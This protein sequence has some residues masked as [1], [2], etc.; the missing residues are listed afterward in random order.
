MKKSLKLIIVAV[1]LIIISI[2]LFVIV[3][4]V[5]IPNS[6][7]NAA[8]TLM[9]NGN[10]KE[11]IAAFELLEGY[12]DSDKKIDECNIAIID[13]KYNNAISKMNEAKFTE[14]VSIFETLNGY[15][16]SVDKIKECNTAINNNNYNEALS[17][18]DSGDIIKAYE[19]LVSLNGYKD[20]KEKAQSIFD[21]YKSEKLKQVN[22]GDFVFFGSYE[23][24]N[25][26]SNGKEDVEWLV[27]DKED[28]KALLISKYALDYISYHDGSSYTSIWELCD[29][30]EWLN[31]NF[32]NSA[33]STNEKTMIPTVENYTSERNPFYD[34]TMLNSSQ[35]KIFILDINEAKKY[36]S[37]NSARICK[38]TSYAITHRTN[39]GNN[40]C[41]WWLRGAGRTQQTLAMFVDDD[42]TIDDFGTMVGVNYVGVRPALWLDLNKI[43]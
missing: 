23:Q 9:N 14:A 43:S 36:F 30:R 33:F 15:K 8:L 13:G 18:I 7:Y 22:V 2:T 34:S 25:N 20:S 3:K 10:Y 32:I 16:N 29:L 24:D 12:K 41:T 39:N 17:L 11:A 37:S 28:N 38:P 21:K 40:S 5:I 4:T 19:I 42:G 31:G 6:K 26:I 27:L 35:D 1:S